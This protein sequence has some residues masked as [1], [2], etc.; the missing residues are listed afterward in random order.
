VI[1]SPPRQTFRQTYTTR[2]A[3][4]VLF[5]GA[6]FVVWMIANETNTTSPIPYAIE[7][8][9]LV[10][11]VVFWIMIGKTVLTIQDEGVRRTSAFGTKELEWHQV[12]EYRYRVV[13]VQ[14]GGGLGYLALAAMRRFG[15]RRATMNLYLTLIG[16]EG[17]KIAITSFYKN[18]YDAVGMVLGSLHEKM[19]ARIESEINSTGAAFGPLRLTT[20]DVQWK[21]NEPVPLTELTSAEITG[22]LLRIRKKGKMLSMVSVRSDKVPNV[23]LLLESMEKL[24]VGASKIPVVDPLARVRI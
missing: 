12:R 19:R 11:T 6:A 5:L 4:A 3:L 18:A 9:L 15:G 10:L 1:L 20:R 16:E 8:A 21:K 2:I 14:A 13:P 7:G 23:L 24:G 17:T 22:Q